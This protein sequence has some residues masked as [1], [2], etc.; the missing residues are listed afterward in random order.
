MTVINEIPQLKTFTKTKKKK[1]WIENGKKSYL[2]PKFENSTN[3][4]F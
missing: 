4:N 3:T 2:N 1:N